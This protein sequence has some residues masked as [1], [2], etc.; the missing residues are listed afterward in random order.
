MRNYMFRCRQILL[1]FTSLALVAA[2]LTA[3]A[4]LGD[5]W[6]KCEQIPEKVLRLH[7]LANSDSERDQTL[8]RKVRDA[9]LRESGVLFS[10]AKTKE[11]AVELA[12]R[13]RDALE[14]AARSAL[15]ENGCTEPVSASLERTY[16]NTRT[17]GEITLPAGCYDALQVRIGKGEG[18]NW[19]CVMFPSLCVPSAVGT[20]MEDVLT[21]EE[22]DVVR[23]QG[24]DIRFQ[25][26]EW[27]E[28]V[29][30]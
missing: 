22:M 9:V 26:V 5:F 30:G 13:N 24:F 19:W 18:H 17:Y 2:M 28:S 21:E 11:E 25:V 4:S 7:V 1:F 29:F 23:T 15:R 20:K 6:A 14:A 12:A 3:A 10:K 16:F 27:Y 8:K